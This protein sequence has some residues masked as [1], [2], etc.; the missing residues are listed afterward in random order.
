MFRETLPRP[1]SRRA[2]ARPYIAWPQDFGRE[3][4]RQGRLRRREA[5]ETLDA[6]VRVQE[7]RPCDVRPPLDPVARSERRGVDS[8]DDRVS[9]S[10]DSLLGRLFVVA[11]FRPGED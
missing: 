2:G 6:R 1:F 5:V 7:G 4:W 3:P 10:A 8:R 11:G 9:R